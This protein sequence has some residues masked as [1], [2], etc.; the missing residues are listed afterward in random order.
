M[1]DR[2]HFRQAADENQ[3]TNVLRPRVPR[4]QRDDRS[5]RVA[6]DDHWLLDVFGNQ[7]LEI[8]DPGLHRVARRGTASG[9]RQVDRDDAIVVLQP[10]RKAAEEVRTAAES[11]DR[12]NRWTRPD[13]VHVH[14]TPAGGGEAEDHATRRPAAAG[15]RRPRGR[16]PA[17]PARWDTRPVVRRAPCR[18]RH[19]RRQPLRP[20]TA[21]VR[22][23]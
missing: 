7:L 11:V 22:S 4:L 21:R 23:R 19:T 12:K 20:R 9:T 6:D 13:V 5:H 16:T 3:P 2:S 10:L 15:R 1:D 14:T 18:S 17:A 8:G